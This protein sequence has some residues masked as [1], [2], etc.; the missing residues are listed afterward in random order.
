M[1]QLTDCYYLV[2]NRT[3]AYICNFVNSYMSQNEETTDEYPFPIYTHEVEIT[4][5]DLNQLMG[6]LEKNETSIYSIYWRNS[7]KISL[8]RFCMAFYTDDGKVILGVSLK[9]QYRE[10]EKITPVFNEIRNYL[11]TDICCITNEEAPPSNSKEFIDFCK[12]RNKD[13]NYSFQL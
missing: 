2:D 5:S 3:T 7:D 4:F 10:N 9:G 6:H 13:I 12:E 11:N 8:I 1:S